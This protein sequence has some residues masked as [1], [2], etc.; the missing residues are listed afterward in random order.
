MRFLF[1]GQS[2]ELADFIDLKV[3]L[4]FGARL[5][6]VATVADA[7]RFIEQVEAQQKALE[8]LNASGVES[9]AKL[10]L[11]KEIELDALLVLD[12]GSESILTWIENI[13]PNVP[14]ILFS[15]RNVVALDSKFVLSA[16]DVP[17]KLLPLLQSCFRHLSAKY[18]GAEYS[19]VPT[20]LLLRASPL[21]SDVYIRLSNKKFV[22][23]FH[24]G[25]DFL[26]EDLE[27]Y[28][29]Q[30]SIEH[31]FVAKESIDDF[32]SYATNDFANI[33]AR[34]DLSE[35]EA[36]DLA[37]DSAKVVRELI[38]TIG[39]SEKVQKVAK[40]N[41]DAT[42]KSIGKS[43]S[44]TKLFARFNKNK[45]QYLSDHSYTLSY[46]ACMVAYNMQWATP[47]TFAKLTMAAMFHDIALTDN[48]LAQVKNKEQLYN[49]DP[50][51]EESEK[52]LFLQHP[53]L[54]ADIVRKFKEVPP[55]VDQIVVQH[56]EH[57][58][59]TGFPRGL[60]GIN[61]SPLAAVLIIAHFIVH[62]MYE[63]EGDFM[64]QDHFERIW[65]E[66][67]SG[68][69]FREIMKSMKENIAA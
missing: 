32:L 13:A 69:S 41:V 66:F 64:L 57:P 59:G 26:A 63:A 42:I 61:I 6:H 52:E 43:P 10:E 1:V 35:E 37:K 15:E 67:S 40:Q 5:A 18:T 24:K 2:R 46:V 62:L 47:S 48:V 60:K 55:D 51:F 7:E 68:N 23:V 34:A 28:G 21:F 9:K 31:L 36:E 29:N 33:L 58:N 12:D 19:P 49:A 3:T 16:K 30:K 38:H 65:Q 17:E 56:H 53:Q 39:F 22:K 50:P 8:I 11:A 45:D 25:A 27:H 54:A 44:L 20:R 4:E 14:K